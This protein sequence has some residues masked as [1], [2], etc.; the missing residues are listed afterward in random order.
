MAVKQ[1]GVLACFTPTVTPYVNLTTASGTSVTPNGFNF[2]TCPG[3]TMMSGKLLIN[4]AKIKAPIHLHG[5][6][7]KQLIEI[8]K[9]IKSADWVFSSWRSH[10]HCL[11]K[12]VP[13][14]RLYDDILSGKS[15][16]LIY[17]E[18]NIFTS[19]IVAGIVPI[20]LGT[21]M[22]IKKS[23]KQDN[24][25][26]GIE[27][28][29]FIRKQTTN[30]KR[31]LS[32]DKTFKNME[33]TSITTID[34]DDLLKDIR[35]DFIFTHD[36]FTTPIAY[37]L[38]KKNN[39]KYFVDVHEHA[40]SQKNTRGFFSNLKIKI[41][42]NSYIKNIENE[43]YTKSNGVSTV[44]DGL[45]LILRDQYPKIKNLITVRST[46][47]YEKHEPKILNS[48]SKIEMLYHGILAPGRGLETYI[49]TM[50]F[51]PEK[52]CLKIRGTGTQDYI[53]S[54]N[55]LRNAFFIGREGN[56]TPDTVVRSHVL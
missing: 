30:L 14:K 36:Y 49:K 32:K 12:G 26:T 55:E 42:Q 1:N 9:G 46:P 2:Y 6:N 7:E 40:L 28:P 56:R 43:F 39:S 51:L 18:F 50:N 13:S 21:A 8:F 54:L 35:V 23:N 25:S 19:A 10:Y 38:A 22:A 15:I 52:Y 11:L 45:N 33:D 41:F 29:G 20:A 5:G 17:Q 47:F 44:S 16:T 53:N 31:S 3:A 27:L 48:D 24:V 34:I 4:N 37:K